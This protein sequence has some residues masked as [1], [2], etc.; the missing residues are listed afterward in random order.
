MDLVSGMQHINDYTRDGFQFYTTD[1][2]ALN[3]SGVAG[4]V[5]ILLDATHQSVTVGIEATGLEPD[6][7]HIQHIHGFD[8]A[9]RRRARP[10]RSMPIMTASSSSARA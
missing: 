6:Q 9:A 7:M 4:K 8:D 10:S 2:V 3:N 1:L 5:T